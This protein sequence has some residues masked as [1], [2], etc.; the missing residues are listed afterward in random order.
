[1]RNKLEMN[2]L[3]IRIVFL[4]MKNRTHKATGYDVLGHNNPKKGIKHIQTPSYFMIG[5][6][7]DLID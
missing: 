3:T 7:D 6:N 1:M 5:E 4:Y 2:W